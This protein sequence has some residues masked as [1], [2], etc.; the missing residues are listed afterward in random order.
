VGVSQWLRRVIL[1]QFIE[2][3]DNPESFLS[4][5]WFCAGQK[6]AIIDG[7]HSIGDIV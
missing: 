4:E 5:S 6:S 3:R 1:S 7:Y 2:G